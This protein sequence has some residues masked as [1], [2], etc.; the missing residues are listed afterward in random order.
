MFEFFASGF[1]Y[2]LAK[3]SLRLFLARKRKLKPQQILDLRQKWKP[4]FE[5]KIWDN[6]KNK[7]RSDVIVR[8]INRIDNYPNIEE[9]RGISPWFKVNL[10]DTYERGIIVG[11]HYVSLVRYA[12]N[13]WRYTDCIKG[14]KEDINVIMAGKICYENIENVD[15]DGDQ[16]Y[17]YPHIYCYFGHKSAPYESVGFYEKRQNPG[18][19]PYYS[20]IASHESVRRLSKRLG[21]KSPYL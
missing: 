5:Q 4:L 17:H 15:W 8:D 21:I 3:D 7:L 18:S 10:I 16:Y 19:R 6:F 2:S 9:K 20:E 1:F 12:D 11:F 14:E 13:I